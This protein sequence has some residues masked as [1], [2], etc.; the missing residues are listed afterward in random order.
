MGYCFMAIEKIKT[1][2]QFTAKY[3]HNYRKML[4]L[5]ADPELSHK[6]K[7]LVDLK[8][9]QTYYQAFEERMKKL[10]YYKDHNIRSNGVLGLEVVLTLSREDAAKIDL[11]EWKKSNVEWLKETF[12]RNPEKYGSNLLS[13]MCHEDESTIHIHA[14]IM[15]VDERGRLNAFSFTN[16]PKKMRFLQDSYAAKMKVHNLQRGIKGSKANKSKRANFSDLKR[17]YDSIN[18][19]YTRHL[20][21]PERNE[22]MERYYERAD[23]V[24][25]NQN[26][27]IFS[28][29]KKIERLEIERDS[30]ANQYNINLYEHDELMKKEYEKL[31]KKYENKLGNIEEALR[32]IEFI[33]ELNEKLEKCPDEILEEFDKAMDNVMLHN[34][35]DKKEDR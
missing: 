10:D 4:V 23:R 7:E 12:D 13:A 6:N 34:I 30:L 27:K 33:D 17:Y 15:P 26:L 29:E 8:E 25:V 35:K 32:K 5:N 21:E 1:K 3:N 20:P 22:S 14:I 28:L 19:I 16:G 18:K 24:Y 9:N 2:S 11:E 31:K